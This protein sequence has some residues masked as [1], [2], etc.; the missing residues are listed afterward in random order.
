M[1]QQTEEKNIELKGIFHIEDWQESADSEMSGGAKLTT[2]KVQQ[3]YEGDIVGTSKTQYR[4]Y[5]KTDGN[6]YFNG[7][8]KISGSIR[9]TTCQLVLKHD[10]IFENGQAKSQFTIVECTPLYEMIGKT[11]RFISTQ[12]KQASYCIANNN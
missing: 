8:E 5:Y 10:G 4:M 7:F 11:G 2:A 6:A 3:R 9:S 1:R 12:A